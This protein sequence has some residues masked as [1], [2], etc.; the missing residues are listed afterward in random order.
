MDK[1]T[2][3]VTISELFW[4]NF[5]RLSDASLRTYLYLYRHGVGDRK[6]TT[7][8]QSIHKSE[9][10]VRRAL[11]ELR[12]EKLV[13]GYSVVIDTNKSS[14]AE[15]DTKGADVAK[16]EKATVTKPEAQGSVSRAELAGK[17]ALPAKPDTAPSNPPPVPPPVSDFKKS[18]SLPG[19]EGEPEGERNPKPVPYEPKGEEDHLALEIA[20]GLGE[21]SKLP[22]YR[23]YMRHYGKSLVWRVYSEVRA[24]PTSQIRK[25]RAALFT[26]LIRKYATHQN[27]NPRS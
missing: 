14:S 27:E 16:P 19:S 3:Q 7:L 8:S 6:V 25:S 13:Q 1:N 2:P 9:R 22:M 23:F 11:Q 18:A 24:V 21:E 12:K 15:L 20:R 17:P 10:T 4:N 26:H 5:E